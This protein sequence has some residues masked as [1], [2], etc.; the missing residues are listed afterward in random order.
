MV[1]ARD[2]GY[3]RRMTTNFPPLILGPLTVE[4]INQTIGTELQ[5]ELVRLRRSFELLRRTPGHDGDATLVAVKMEPAERGDYR[6][7]SFCKII[8]RELH[9]KRG[10]RRIP[11]GGAKQRECRL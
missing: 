5:P 11:A 10:K 6:V 3:F 1:Q 7:V 4:M 8:A 9:N 2:C